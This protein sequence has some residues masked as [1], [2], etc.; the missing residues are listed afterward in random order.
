[1]ARYVLEQQA[2]DDGR[3]FCCLNG[4]DAAMAMATAFT[5]TGSKA[6]TENE[7]AI[8][9]YTRTYTP[10]RE[11]LYSAQLEA[12][13]RVGRQECAAA[14]RQRGFGQTSSIRRPDMGLDVSV[15]GADKDWSAAEE[16]QALS[17]SGSGC[18]LTE[19]GIS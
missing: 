16:F 19:L 1:M 14:G 13:E 10:G 15:P 18:R 4:D 11:R 7:D 2:G 12:V 6:E 8:T 5:L 9:A 3:G 17:S